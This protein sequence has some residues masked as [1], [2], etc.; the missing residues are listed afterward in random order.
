MDE[1]VF[2]PTPLN[3]ECPLTAYS[4][5]DDTVRCNSVLSELRIS[6]SSIETG[7]RRHACPEGNHPGGL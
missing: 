6:H 1:W 2:F 5:T 4:S 7:D 3:S